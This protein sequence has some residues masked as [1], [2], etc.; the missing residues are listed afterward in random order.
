[1]ARPKSQDARRLQMV[2]AA[3]RAIGERGLA[4]VRIKDIADQAGMSPGSVLYYYPELDDLLIEVHQETV[5]Q[6][7]AQREQ[8]LDG[9]DRPIDQL[10]TALHTG[11]PSGPDDVTARLLY[12]MHARCEASPAHAALMTNLFDREVALYLTILRSAK[13]AGDV[14]LRASAETIARTLVALEDGLGL[15]IVSRTRPMTLDAALP[16]MTSCA[17]QF[18]GVTLST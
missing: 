17:E 12:G 10:R 16:I 5:D 14:E 9:L 13:E 7:F 2:D 18:T 15:H 8:F 11:L 1:M 4:N 6:Y 3:G